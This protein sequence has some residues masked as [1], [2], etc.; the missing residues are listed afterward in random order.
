MADLL[1][2]NAPDIQDI[3]NNE[4]MYDRGFSVFEFSLYI[5]AVSRMTGD[6]FTRAQVLAMGDKFF[7]SVVFNLSQHG[8][9]YETIDQF[10]TRC[11]LNKELSL[12]KET[13]DAITDELIRQATLFY[14]PEEDKAKNIQRAMVTI[15]KKLSSYTIQ[16]ITQAN[17]EDL[18]FL[19]INSPGIDEFDA[20]GYQVNHIKLT[21]PHIDLYAK[22]SSIEELEIVNMVHDV[23]ISTN[24]S[25]VGLMDSSITIP[26]FTV[27]IKP[28]VEEINLGQVHYGV[29]NSLQVIE[30]TPGS[31]FVGMEFFN[32]LTDEQ[33]LGI[34]FVN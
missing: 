8:D 30:G 15:F 2:L 31:T 32:A 7:E 12:P 28:F 10:L 29:G 33:T 4:H 5:E 6:S 18:I 24:G 26:E 21:T 1:L 27:K 23:D 13:Y 14:V 34:K 17:E 16:F 9:D 19:E 20:H 22:G 11:R 25:L 3:D